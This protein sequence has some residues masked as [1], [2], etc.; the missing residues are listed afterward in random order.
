MTRRGCVPQLP[1]ILDRKDRMPKKELE[2]QPHY[3][4]S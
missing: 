1:M 4:R 2:D 3:V